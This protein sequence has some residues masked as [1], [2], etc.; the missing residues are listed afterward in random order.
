MFKTRVPILLS[1][2]IMITNKKYRLNP[3]KKFD[4]QINN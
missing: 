3:H 4:I 1:E 2:T